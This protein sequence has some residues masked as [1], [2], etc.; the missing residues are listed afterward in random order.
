MLV[1]E[2]AFEFE[3][4]DYHEKIITL[5]DRV[6]KLQTL[7]KDAEIKLN[8]TNIKIITPNYTKHSNMETNEQDNM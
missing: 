5:T 3:R 4:A 7:Y 6:N 1:K 8:K 2:K